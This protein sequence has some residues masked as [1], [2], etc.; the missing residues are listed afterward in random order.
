MRIALKPC[1]W[2]RLG[3]TLVVVHDPSRQIELDDPEGHAEAL[4]AA[5][6]AGPQTVAELRERLAGGGV[7]VSV[8]DLRD[9]LE[10]FDSVR[11]LEDADDRTLGTPELDARH[12][13]NLAFFGTFASLAASRAELQRRLRRAHVLQ[14]GAGG[15][16]S[17][18]L[19]SLAG[20]GVGRLTLLD[21]D[22]VEPRNF[23]RQF[24]YRELDIGRSKVRRAAEWVREFDSHIEVAVVERRV[25]GPGDVA[26]LLDG[27]DLVVSG[28]DRPDAVDAWVNEACVD[29][30]VP[31]IRGGMGGA[32][33]RYFSV[34]PGRS[35]CYAALL[36]RREEVTGRG[37]ADAAG[38]RL[39]ATLPRVNRGIGP[40]AMLAGSLVA[41]E[42]LRYLTRFEPPFAAGASVHVD[43]ADGCRQRREPWPDD[44]D[45]RLCR[46]AR[47]RLAP[48]ATP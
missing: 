47:E 25:D 17:N 16:G 20:L 41:F 14:L 26:A 23:A 40:A 5:L 3:D 10:A 12:F 24:L 43:L 21:H 11:L 46:H 19:Q 9:A 35:P 13:S 34:D 28:I 27:V 6:A 7:E 29:A 37:D 2:E 18:V 45:C 42:A 32:E 15:L 48:A 36:R 30:G 4:L 38:S 31:W 33:L 44:P 39:S 8:A 1:A 22:R